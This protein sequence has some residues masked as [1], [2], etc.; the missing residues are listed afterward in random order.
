MSGG[1]FF[2][3][4]KTVAR[5]AKTAATVAE[6]IQDKASIVSEAAAKCEDRLKSELCPFC[7][8]PA[9]EGL[10]LCPKHLSATA[11]VAKKYAGG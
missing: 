6:Q 1:D 9:V 8:E 2:K 10:A 3:F 5:G 7:G 4:L 11:R